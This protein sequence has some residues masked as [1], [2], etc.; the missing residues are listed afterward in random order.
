[1]KRLAVMALA[2]CLLAGC[3]VKPSHVDAPFGPENDRFPQIYPNPAHDPAPAGDT[4]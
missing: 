2:C 4:Q 3:G 1:M